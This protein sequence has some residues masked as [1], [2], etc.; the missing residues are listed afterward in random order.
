MIRARGVRKSFRPAA[1]ASQL[2]RFRLRGAPVVALDGVDLDAAAGEIVGL[3]GPNGAGKSTLLRI[4]AGL[5]VPSSGA[6][7]VAGEDATR[8]TVELK[9]KIGYVAAEERG[10]TPHLS[11][12]E[13]LAFYGALYG[14]GRRAALERADELL[15]KVGASAVARRPLRELSTGQ[16]RRVA[17][18]RGLLNAPAVL[19]LDEPT[20][21]L[22]PAGADGLHT[23][24]LALAAAGAAAIVATH[25]RDEARRLCTRVAV[26][27]SGRV[28]ALESPDRAGARLRPGA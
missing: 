12:R 10:L 4:L 7:T 22:D 16:R 15:E 23:Q 26:L 20:R 19:L 28:I 3:M 27:E 11:P 25:D 17:L 24:L 6:V 18:A 9:R 13:H 5:L 2:M 14:L 1:S 8:G 21:G